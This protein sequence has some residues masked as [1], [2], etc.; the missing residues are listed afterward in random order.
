MVKSKKLKVCQFIDSYF[1][2]MDG[3]LIVAHNYAKSLS[4]MGFESSLV[5]PGLEKYKK[6]GYKSHL[7][8]S[9]PVP[10]MRPYRIGIPQL[11]PFFYRKIKNMKFD[12]VHSHSPFLSGHLASRI[13]KHQNIPHITTFHTKWKED[14]RK[15]LKA[16]FLVRIMLRYVS[17][18]YNK[19]DV[20]W[21]PNDSTGKELVKYGFKGKYEIVKN[22]CDID[23]DKK[24]IKKLKEKALSDKIRE[25]RKDFILLF[26]GQHRWEKGVKIILEA[27]KILKDKG[28]KFKMIFVG[29]G[30]AKEEMEK[31]VAD[32]NLKENVRFTG[33]ILEREKL[34]EMYAAADLYI[35]PSKYDNS[36]LTVQEA[37]AF[38]LPSVL[39]EGSSAAEPITDKVNGFTIKV[40][41]SDLSEKIIYIMK[42]PRLLKK[43]GSNARKTLYHPWK[44]VLKEVAEKYS[45][46]MEI[47]RKKLNN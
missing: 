19:A 3:G 34:K 29:E 44:K 46:I 12:I 32:N 37:A 35:F 1:P 15:V 4:D 31:F 8:P 9:I 21:V 47:N 36:P 38:Y 13:S 41:P 14:F 28:E 10:G 16:D 39:I 2:T 30:Y 27:L 5:A 20:V 24:Q 33:L 43:A 18:F 23:V 45:D 42:N 25:E 22:G 6:Q 17:S 11:N 40:S 7:F 26:V